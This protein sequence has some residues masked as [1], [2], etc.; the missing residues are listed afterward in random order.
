[1]WSTRLQEN[2]VDWL[3]RSAIRHRRIEFNQVMQTDV[4]FASTADHPNRWTD[5]IVPD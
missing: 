1:M 2:V 3:M 4:G 5:G